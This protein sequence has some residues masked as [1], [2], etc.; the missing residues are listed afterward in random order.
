MSGRLFTR[1]IIAVPL[2]LA[3]ILSALAATPGRQGGEAEAAQ[4]A[5]A[6]DRK[7][8]GLHAY[9]GFSSIIAASESAWI[10]NYKVEVSWSSI[11]AYQGIYD[12]T[13][14]DAMVG[15]ILA[16]GCESLFF[17]VG[18]P[19][20]AW[21]WDG[22]YGSMADKAPPQNLG[23]WYDF[24]AAVAERYASV[25]D[26]YEIWNEPGWDRDSEA[27]RNSG[28]YHFGGQVETDYLPLL[29][30]GYTAVKEKDPT[31]SVICGALM[32]TLKDDPSAG[33]ENYALL[34]DEVNRPGQD[35]SMKV[36]ADLP[37]VAE[38]PMYF[39]YQ[40]AWAGGHDSMG[41][42]SPQTEWYFAEG[43][44]RPGFNTWLCLQNPQDTAALVSVDYLCGDGA[45]VRRD[46]SVGAN[47][48]FTIPVHTDGLGIGVHDSTHGDVSIK[49]SSSQPIV[50]ERPMYF[51]YNGTW[52]GGHDAMGAS[53][54]QTEWYFAEGC[55]RPGFNTW[56]CLQNP[57]D[58][59][60]VVYLDYFCGDGANVRRELT[61]NPR[62]RF[63][64][65]V[66]TDGLG[67]GVHNSTHGDVSIKVSSSQPMVAER[68][69]YFN[70][71]GAWAGG[72]DAM[73]ATSPQTEWYF[74]EGC[75]RPGFNTWLCLQNPGDAAAVVSIDYLCGDGANVRRELMVGPRSRF[76]VPVHTDGLGIG[77][78]NSTH[79]DVSIKVSSSQPMVA[80]RPMY[81]DY[82]GAWKG[83][84]DSM[85]A[86]SP[87]TEWYFAEGCTGFSIQ[88]YL[89]LQNPHATSALATLTFMMT[90]GET[91]SRV[92]VLPPLS[93]MTFDINMLIGFHGTCDMVAVHPYKSPVY[94]G[95]FYANVV[96]TLRGRGAGQEVVTSEVG[97]PHYSDKQPGSFSE[98][99]Q[100]LALGEQGVKGLFDAGCRK[101]WVY[102]DVDEVPGTSW[103][104]NY[105][106]LFSHTGQPHTAW[107]TYV[108]WQQQ[109]PAYPK[110]PTTWP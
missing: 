71:Q 47:S 50:A 42:T 101:I 69:M 100:A 102:R 54:P 17:L 16:S 12:W 72:H 1:T 99:G 56:L 22:Q 92:M 93:R 10:H 60:A 64:V 90:K 9:P 65:P 103:D 24:C 55:T 23:D 32:Y 25:V 106:G 98:G 14:L 78:H 6:A 28:V 109:L 48:R 31:A 34:F 79:G 81:F 8:L 37:I 20:P 97:W 88:E 70:Y 44:T 85:G 4:Q 62:S 76:T 82:N 38:R 39:N 18:G 40:G 45:N 73:G 5:A 68:P 27:Y 7:F 2:A 77:V 59:A 63:T 66:H 61:V 89:C 80:E 21:A 46:I 15:E 51:N 107:Y 41:A 83:G 43:C 86:T 36:E 33:T 52:A 67:I 110:L 13:W 35:V 53:S 87:Q 11:E 30:L 26:F 74:A 105:Y 3:L 49:V 108:Q 75:T 57:G 84:H 29:Q 19:T 96:N 95:G 94:W 104:G 91:F 58:A